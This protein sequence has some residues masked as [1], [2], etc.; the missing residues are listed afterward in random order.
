VGIGTIR[1]R[2]KLVTEL[3]VGD[4]VTVIEGLLRYGRKRG[5][6]TMVTDRYPY[7]YGVVLEDRKERLWFA[8]DELREDSGD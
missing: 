6:L 1:G 2:R 8:R 3:K 5:E 7:N 4:K